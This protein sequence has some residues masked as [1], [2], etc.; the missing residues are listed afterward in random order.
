MFSLLTLIS[1]M[2]N[3]VILLEMKNTPFPRAHWVG[4]LT[5]F[6]KTYDY[7]QIR[8][9]K[10]PHSSGIAESEGPVCWICPKSTRS[11]PVSEPLIK[12]H[13]W[14]VGTFDKMNA[15]L[16]LTATVKA[17]RSDPGKLQIGPAQQIISSNSCWTWSFYE[18]SVE[19]RVKLMSLFTPSL[20]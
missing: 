6:A 5:H 8:H 16:C 2:I 13:D 19:L 4:M 11:N 18:V 20:C 15:Y 14:E 17:V 1:L 3:L 7:A 10:W 9:R 12:L